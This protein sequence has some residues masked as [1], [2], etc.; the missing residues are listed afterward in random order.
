MT[1]GTQMDLDFE[2]HD[3]RSH[4]ARFE[5]FR[6][7][8]PEV[9]AELR[10]LCLQAKG[11]GVKKIG[12]RMVWEVMRWNLTVQTVRPANDFKLNDHFH[13]RYARLLNEEPE[14]RGMFELR[15]LRS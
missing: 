6:R 4:Q 13:S 5:E 8:N 7:N 15:E 11:L 9:L 2:S 10:R 12:I 14:L 3:R 1:M